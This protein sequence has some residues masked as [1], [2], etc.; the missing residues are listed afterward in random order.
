VALV[1][2]VGVGSWW[3]WRR[4]TRPEVPDIPL[5]GADPAIAA[6]VREAQ[7][8]VRQRPRSAEAWGRLGM[9]LCANQLQQW[10]G[11]P[12]AQAAAFAPRDERWP[13]LHGVAVGTAD[14]EA[15]LPYLRRAAELC[16]SGE[17][18]QTAAHLRLAEAL[19]ANGHNEE[20]ADHFQ[21]ALSLSADH[22]CAHYGLGVLALARGDLARSK[23]HLLHC[24]SSPLTRQ[25]AS[26]QLAALCKRLKDD[27]GADTHAEAARQAPADTPWPDPFLSECQAF[28]VGR[29]TLEKGYTALEQKGDSAGALRAARQL[30]RDYPD[31]RSYLTLGI[32][33]GRVGQYEESEWYLRKSLELQ[34]RVA[35][36]QYYLSLALFA[37]GEALGRQAGKK[38]ESEAKYRESVRW[39]RQ[40]VELNDRYAEA[41]FQIGLALSC[42]GER[43]G[44]IEAFRRA[45]RSRPELAEPHLWLGKALAEDGQTEEAVVHLENAVRLAPADDTRPRQALKEVRGKRKAGS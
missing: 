32:I 36:A 15:A 37:Q 42:L 8:E 28:A 26:V 31:A 29:K 27:R 39:A 10:A 13:Y 24:A 44:A 11:E 45:V 25:R 6:A 3:G 21:K 22:V 20:A 23:E 7:E 2:L 34:P 5:D 40:A 30:A 41:H 12:F 17:A 14:P 38:A 16:N 33:L 35:Q 4:F 18:H 1:V 19:L 9:V 43:P